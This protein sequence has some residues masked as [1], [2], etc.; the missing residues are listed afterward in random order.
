MAVPSVREHRRYGRMRFGGIRNYRYL[1]ILKTQKHWTDESISGFGT[2]V[3][4]G[5]DVG[6]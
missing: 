3:Y 5:P 2:Q 6:P 1:C 4:T